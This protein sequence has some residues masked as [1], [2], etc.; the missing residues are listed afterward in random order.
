[1]DA[2]TTVAESGI[3]SASRST[4]F[5][6]SNRKYHLSKVVEELAIVTGSTRRQYVV[7]QANF[8]RFVGANRD[9][10]NSQNV[11]LRMLDEYVE[12]DIWNSR[13]LNKGKVSLLPTTLNLHPTSFCYRLSAYSSFCISK[14]RT[15]TNSS[16]CLQC[17]G[18]IW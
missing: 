15:Q 4:L 11:N 8:N 1:M 14:C 9:K 17:M 2:E 6:M 12:T 10:G 18:R 7:A 5:P 16:M 13:A 3:E